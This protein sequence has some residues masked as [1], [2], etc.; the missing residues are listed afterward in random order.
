MQPIVLTAVKDIVTF[1]DFFGKDAEFGTVAVN[2]MLVGELCR[3]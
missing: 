1:V 2:E 3:G